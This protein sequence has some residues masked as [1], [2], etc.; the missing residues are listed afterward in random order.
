[1]IALSDKAQNDPA[2]NDLAFTSDT[3]LT[4]DDKSPKQ[5]SK[6]KRLFKWEPRV[7]P[8]VG[9]FA[10][11]QQL[12]RKIHSLKGSIEEISTALLEL[13]TLIQKEASETLQ[14]A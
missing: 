2:P 10:R 9:P 12:E 8:E 13:N 3:D 1:M 6:Y 4:S 5:E 14:T 7:K 11:E